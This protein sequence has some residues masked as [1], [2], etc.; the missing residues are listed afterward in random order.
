MDT[1]HVVPCHV[2]PCH[3]SFCHGS[4][5][6]GSFWY[7]VRVFPCRP[8]GHVRS[9]P[10]HR[11]GTYLLTDTL[12]LHAHSRLVGEGLAVLL[13]HLAANRRPQVQAW[14]QLKEE[15]VRSDTVALYADGWDDLNDLE[16]DFI[17]TSEMHR[18]KS[19]LV[20]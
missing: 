1:G 16:A 20:A 5:W 3:G 18:G 12:R 13:S 9:V 10:T 4:F 8:F 14:L 11:Y 19:W 17:T 7:G 15:L 2:V 6:Y